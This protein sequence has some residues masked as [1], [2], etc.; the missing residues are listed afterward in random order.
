M[1]D[2]EAT[3]PWLRGNAHLMRK[4]YVRE[5]QRLLQ[6][7]TWFLANYYLLYCSII[8]EIKIMPM[9]VMSMKVMFMKV[10]SM[11]VCPYRSCPWRS[12]SWRSF[13]WGH[14]HDGIEVISMVAKR[15]CPWRH[16]GHV[17]GG[18]RSCLWRSCPCWS[19]L[20]RSC[21]CDNDECIKTMSPEVMSIE[22]ID[23]RSTLELMAKLLCMPSSSS[24]K[25]HHSQFC[26]VESL[27]R[28]HFPGM[29]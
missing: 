5:M 13:P 7:N 18:M 10:K 2:C 21:P 17:H 1:I 16:W 28:N 4:K 6:S 22:V 23:W 11:K 24:S 26:C 25:R 8:L 9:E 15:S 19:C 3:L 27:R 12:C 20:W 29:E 14:V